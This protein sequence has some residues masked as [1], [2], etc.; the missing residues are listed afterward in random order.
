MNAN[1]NPLIA[2][3]VIALTVIGIGAWTWASGQAKEIGGPSELR[4]APNGHLFIQMQ[5]QLLE[6]DEEGKFVARHD[7]SDLGVD[8]VIGALDFFANGDILVRRGPDSRTL[9]QNI[10]AFQRKTNTQSIAPT[11][12]NTG[13]ARCDLA[14]KS[15]ETFGESPIDF[16]TA[17][18]LI[19][20]RRTDD[21]YVT[22]TSRHLIR[23][24]SPSG[25]PIGGP[26]AGFRFPNDVV[27][28][29]EKLFITDTNHHRVAIV[30]PHSQAFGTTLD[31]A[32]VVPVQAKRARQSW[33]SDLARIGDTWWVNNMRSNMRDGGIYVFD[34]AWEFK[35]KLP[36]PSDADPIDIREFNDEVLISDW[37]NDRIY[38]VSQDGQALH[39][40][41]SAG[42]NALVAESSQSRL[43]YYLAAYVGVGMILILIIGLIVNG[44]TPDGPGAFRRQ[45]V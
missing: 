25:M 23:K 30:N 20:D 35:Y 22:D 18:G 29:D 45:G 10:R 21:V 2:A 33:P 11:T 14:T 26:V 39:T 41:S 12:P 24:Y 3:L 40:F 16:K 31:E 8:R 9:L 17:Y 15:C 6:H 7:L 13:L 36:L 27:L 44:V 1:V 28:H 5:N 37:R 4:V 19:I 42:F 34:N 43:K 32:D 38:R